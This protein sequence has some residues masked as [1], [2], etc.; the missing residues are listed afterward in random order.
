MK[1]ICL[2]AV[3][4]LGLGSSVGAQDRGAA[5]PPAMPGAAALVAWGT[6]TDTAYARKA[7]RALKAARLVGPDRLMAYPGKS[8][9]PHGNIV[10]IVSGMATV[11]GRR[12]RVVVK[13]NHRGKGLTPAMV[14]DDPSKHL[15]DIAV[16]IKR[17]AGYDPAHADWFWVVFKPDGSVLKFRDKPVAGRVDTGGT[18]GCIGCHRKYGG[19]DY[20]T[21]TSK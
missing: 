3:L 8:D 14:H 7:W 18:D 21:L 1:R 2:A 12:T 15:A 13:S 9:D 6:A 10:Q 16:M 4:V 11:D 19:A 17:R 20:E 5:A